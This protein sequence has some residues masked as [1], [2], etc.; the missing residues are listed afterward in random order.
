MNTDNNLKSVKCNANCLP[1]INNDKHNLIYPNI[2][3]YT[4]NPEDILETD[5]KFNE[6]DN[7]EDKFVNKN[8]EDF[9][10]SLP[11]IIESKYKENKNKNKK[12]KNFIKINK[13]FPNPE[14]LIELIDQR[15]NY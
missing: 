5:V 10:H 13:I 2:T 1:R 9:N 15:E 8:N 3:N 6:Y 12:V 11:I 14:T 4:I 7:H